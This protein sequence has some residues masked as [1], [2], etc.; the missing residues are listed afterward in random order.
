MKFIKPILYA[1]L[2]IMFIY[3]ISNLFFDQKFE[4]ETSIE[5]ESSPY[6]VYE[7]ISN[8]ENWVNWNPWVTKDTSLEMSYSNPSFDVGAYMNWKSQNTGNGRIELISNEFLKQLDY[9][10]VINQ[11]PPF[12]ANFILQPNGNSV[13]LTWKNFGDLPFLGR[14]FGPIISK[15]IKSDHHIG[16]NQLKDYCQNLPSSNSEIKVAQWDSQYLISKVTNCSSHTIN[17]SLTS[18][19]NDLFVYLAQ[20][21]IMSTQAPFAQYLEFPT[22]PK[23]KDV[24]KLRAGTFIDI[25]IKDSLNNGFEYKQIP[26]S[27]SVQSKHKGDYKTI[28]NTHEKIKSYCQENNYTIKSP[29]YEIYITDPQLNPN[30]ME[31]ETLVV[32]L[33]E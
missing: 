7:Q 11:N 18:I 27:L 25:P 1:L 10:I 14:I 29:P 23:S 26:H 19:Y 4:I 24:V 12:F 16:L 21:G 33:I 6:V 17:A 32:Y 28:F 8:F 20:N 3:F 15:M 22:K 13:V 30:P 9:E 31:W 2:G 5:I